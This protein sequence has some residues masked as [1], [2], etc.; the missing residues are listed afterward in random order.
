MIQDAVILTRVRSTWL[1]KCLLIWLKCSVLSR[2]TH[3]V[4]KLWKWRSHS[5]DGSMFS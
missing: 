5:H 3:L 2:Q 1:K 4:Y